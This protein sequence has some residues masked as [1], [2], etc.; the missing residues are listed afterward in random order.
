MSAPPQ[1]A[2]AE[3]L[4]VRIFKHTA[5]VGAEICLHLQ[6]IHLQGDPDRLT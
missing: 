4:F 2:P 6:P 1:H 5:A 3:F